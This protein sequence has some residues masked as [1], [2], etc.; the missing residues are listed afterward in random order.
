M[1]SRRFSISRLLPLNPPLIYLGFSSGFDRAAGAQ[2]FAQ[3]PFCSINFRRRLAKNPSP[4]VLFAPLEYGHIFRPSLGRHC[5]AKKPRQQ[6]GFETPALAQLY[7]GHNIWA[8]FA[9]Q[10]IPALAAVG[11]FAA[12]LLAGSILWLDRLSTHAYTFDVFARF[13]PFLIS[14]AHWK[15]VL[16]EA[17]ASRSCIP[18]VPVFSLPLPDCICARCSDGRPIK[19]EPRWRLA[20]HTLSLAAALCAAMI[21]LATVQD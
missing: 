14:D 5:R 17:S 9:D 20:N 16:C 7:R 8:R 18:G 2:Y 10:T 3:P 12:S 11:L 15:R 19:G 1:F 21:S 4:A 6:I 13:D